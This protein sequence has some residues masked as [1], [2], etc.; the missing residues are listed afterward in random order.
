MLYLKSPPPNPF[1]FLCAATAICFTK[2]LSDQTVTDIGTTVTL[3]CELSREGLSVEWFKDN[4]KVLRDLK[5]DFVDDKKIH[6]LVISKVDSEDV[7][8]YRCEY[9]LLSTQAKLSVEG[10]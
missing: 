6:K 10:E 4:K 9:K 2:D 7:G 5:H 3:E 1:P 8:N